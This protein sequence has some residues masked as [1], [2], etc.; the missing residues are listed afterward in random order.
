VHGK[1]GGDMAGTADPN[2]PKG[3]SIPY[4][5]MLSVISRGVGWG[6]AIAAQGW[7]GHR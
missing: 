2:G 6:A 7:D 4:D 3:Y 1:L 5:L